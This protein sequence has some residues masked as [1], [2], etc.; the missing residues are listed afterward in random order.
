MDTLG[1]AIPPL[2]P[3]SRRAI[4]ELVKRHLRI[5]MAAIVE[6]ED[7]FRDVSRPIGYLKAGGFVLTCQSC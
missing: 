2:A 1:W 3:R 6:S 4:K 5:Q 7:R